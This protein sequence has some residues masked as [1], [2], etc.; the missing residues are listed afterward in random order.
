MNA[1]VT[2]MTDQT[3]LMLRRGYD[4]DIDTLFRALTDPEAIR[5]WFGPGTA[6]VHH[7]EGEIR[8]GG[9][10]AIEM[11]GDN[12]EEHKVSGEY[13]QVDPPNRVSF[14]WAWASTPENVSEV[15]YALSP[16]PEGGTTLTLTHARLANADARDRHAFGWNGSLDKLGPWLDGGAG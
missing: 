2:E 13:T 11:V 1:P 14:T 3:T 7:A 16:A 15:T 8:V 4:T 9:R 5:Q 6:K 12:C 10:W